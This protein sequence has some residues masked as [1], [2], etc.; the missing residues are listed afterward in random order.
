MKKNLS[1]YIVICVVMVIMAGFG[2]KAEAATEV[3]ERATALQTITKNYVP[4]TKVEFSG[5]AKYD[6]LPVK[7]T[8][9]IYMEKGE[10]V[11][12]SLRAPFVGEAVRIEITPDSLV[13][14]NKMGKTYCRESMAAV[15]KI[16]PDALN[17]IQSFLLGRIIILGEGELNNENARGVEIMSDAA[18]GWMLFPADV[19]AGSGVS[20]AYGYA[21]MPGGRTK[22]MLV[23]VMSEK[24]SVG[25]QYD[26]SSKGMD[27]DFVIDTP[28]KKVE[29]ELDFESVKWGGTPMS[30]VNLNAKYKRV[31]IKQL[32]KSF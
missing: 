15:E 27:M 32:L 7:P 20:A 9:K 23:N 19:K 4:W 3:G 14:V 24:I 25:A 29:A 28:S 1:K 6:A 10:L 26:Y 13:A 22:A 2:R 11:Q 12:V 17:C 8:V 31:S 21:V 18:G 16:L 30:P 5:K